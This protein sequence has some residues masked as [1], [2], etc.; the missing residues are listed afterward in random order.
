[1]IESYHT[2][3]I[4]QF[5]ARSTVIFELSRPYENH[6]PYSLH[7]PHSQ[8]PEGPTAIIQKYK[9]PPPSPLQM[10]SSLGFLSF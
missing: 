4:S 6:K 3:N 5:S 2:R 8:I 9:R 7:P 10:T 1:M